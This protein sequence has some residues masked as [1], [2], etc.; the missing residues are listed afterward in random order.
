MKLAKV[1]VVYKKSTFQLQALEH[2]EP[3][4]IRLMEQ[5][6]ASLARVQ[7]AHA[8]HYDVLERLTADLKAR[9]IEFDQVAR[10]DLDD[11]VANVD[12]IISVGGDG[13]FLDAS[14]TVKDVP[15]LG[16]NSARSSSFGH[17]CLG[18]ETNFAELLD[19]I[20]ADAI[21]PERL[22][23]LQLACSGSLIPELVL[24]EVLC[25]HSNPAGTSRYFIEMDG[26]V[27]EQRSS[28]IWIG[29]AAGSTGALKSC[30]GK[31]MDIT[32]RKYQYVVREPWTRPGQKFA[33]TGGILN[34]DQTL[35]VVSQMRTG[36]LF[37]DGQHIDYSFGLG[38]ELTISVSPHDLLAFI[39]PRVN[40]M[41]EQ[42]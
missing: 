24:N 11:R 1:L 42:G 14:H 28:G 27:E 15:I 30:G 10:A 40:D 39:D 37:L 29:T 5:G 4:F 41:F 20:T 2:K 35:K 19:K 6:H 22:V 18:N 33:F 23:R 9:G 32:E 3:R 34:E 25:A 13:T 7:T 16:I 38:E 8:E 36:S 17:F 12:L 21:K 31:I 26:K